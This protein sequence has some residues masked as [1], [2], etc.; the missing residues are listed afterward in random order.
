MCRITYF[1]IAVFAFAAVARAEEAAVAAATSV[2]TFHCLS[3]YWSPPRG[4]AGR[5]V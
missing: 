2:S 4:E 1:F 3:I 5:Q